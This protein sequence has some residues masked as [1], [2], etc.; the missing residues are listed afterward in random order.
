MSTNRLSAS[1]SD[2]PTSRRQSNQAPPPSLNKYKYSNSQENSKN[3]RRKIQGAKIQTRPSF[4]D[5][6]KKRSSQA[7]VCVRV[8]PDRV[9]S[10]EWSLRAKSR[11]D[12]TRIIDNYWQDGGSHETMAE[13]GH[14]NNTTKSIVLR[15]VNDFCQCR[16]QTILQQTT[17]SIS[18]SN[19]EARQNIK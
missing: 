11:F 19:Q 10:P 13:D 2:V 8:F 3:R 7:C 5:W 6:C 9:T 17:K 15:I 16:P 18:V 4:C 14:A 12:F 1:K